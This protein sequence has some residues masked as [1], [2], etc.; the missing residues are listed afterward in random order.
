MIRINLKKLIFSGCVAFMLPLSIMAQTSQSQTDYSA[1]TSLDLNLSKAIE[2][3]LAENPIMKVADKEIQLKKVADTEAWQNLL[4]QLDASLALSHSIKVAEIRTSMG[5]FKMGMDGS[6]TAQGGLTMTLPL[7]APAVYANMK[8]TKED[9]LVAQEKARNSKL[10]LV[11]QVTKAYFGALLSQDSYKVM[12]KAYDTSK[13]YYDV[14][15]NMYKVGR[16]SEYD[17]ISAEVQM[18]NMNSSVVSAQTG[19]KL[20]Q[21]QLKVL[22]G[23]TADID[24]NITDSL[25]AYENTLLLPNEFGVDEIDNNSNL[26]QLDLNYNLLQKTRKILNTNFMP[27][28]AMQLTGQ[29]QSMSNDNW[30]LFNY[31]YSPSVSLAFSVSIPV[32]R[33]SNWTKLKTN[34]IQMESLL[35]TRQNTKRQLSMAAQ[36]YRENMISTV[37]KLESNKQAVYQADKA[38]TISEKRYEVGK[39]TILEL[40]QSETSLT[41]AELTYHQSIYEYLTNKADLEYTL[42]RD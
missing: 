29:Y 24:L 35:E 20:S 11:N 9:I 1:L 6:T 21:L 27:V 5:S 3:A 18:R 32:F 7:F 14:I 26:K 37:A 25:M 8:L 2:I 22:M 36:S 15:D 17:K 40:N 39:G 31:H 30:N 19:V 23:I 41:Q 10:D 16:V 33:A 13:K 4:P 34:K 42:G 38:V 12:Q 28:V